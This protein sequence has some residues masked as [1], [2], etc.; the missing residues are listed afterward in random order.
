[1]NN[2][3]PLFLL[4]APAG[5]DG[6]PD[7]SAAQVLSCTTATG[8]DAVALERERRRLV[9]AQFLERSRQQLKELDEFIALQKGDQ[10]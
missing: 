5:P 7:L 9:D 2:L 3:L 10:Q 4:L 8:Q 6:M 1:M